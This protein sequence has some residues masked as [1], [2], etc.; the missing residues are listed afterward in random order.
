MGHGGKALDALVA[1]AEEVVR[2]S[3]MPS[4]CPR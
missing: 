3:E 4:T 1:I 2:P